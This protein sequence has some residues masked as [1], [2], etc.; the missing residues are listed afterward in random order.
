MAQDYLS[1][2]LKQSHLIQ[3]II[4]C[5]TLGGAM[6]DKHSARTSL[7]VGHREAQLPVTSPAR[8]T[9]PIVVKRPHLEQRGVTEGLNVQASPSIVTA[10]MTDPLERVSPS[11]R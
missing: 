3:T 4:K 8:P 7:I 1:K 2:P 5:A 9:G 6:R 11:F 10:D